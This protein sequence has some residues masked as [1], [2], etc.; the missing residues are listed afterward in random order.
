MA[1]ITIRDVALRAGVSKS[2]ASAVLNG[3][4]RDLFR[5]STVEKVYEAARELGYQAHAGARLLRQDKNRTTL[6]GIATHAEI[7]N[8]HTVSSL[9]VATHTELLQAGFQP[10]LVI[11]EQMVPGKSFAPFPS[12]EM[13]AGIISIDMTM[14]HRVPDF[15]KVLTT[16][17]PVVALYPVEDHLVDCVTTDRSR[18]IELVCEHLIELGHRRIAFAEAQ[19]FTGDMKIAAWKEACQEHGIECRSEYL[20]SLDVEDH[21]IIRGE[22]AAQKLIEMRKEGNELPTA[23]MCGSDEIALCAMRTLSKAGWRI[24]TDISVAGFDNERHAQY[25]MP[26]LTTVAQPAEAVAKAA[27]DRLGELIELGRGEKAWT[28]KQQLIAPQ[29]MA[30]ESTAPPPFESLR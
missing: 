11:P 29:L 24:G 9:I 18:G 23:L 28:P 5:P 16:R 22:K 10:V 6:V 19:S 17:L 27:V 1:N 14:E 15:Y 26:S 7:L 30:R 21:P 12:P 8:W 20:I 4:R 2:S 3:G 13:L 25:S